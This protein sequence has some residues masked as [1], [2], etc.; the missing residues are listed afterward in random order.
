MKHRTA[1]IVCLLA[2]GAVAA[3]LMAAPDDPT[4]SVRLVNATSVP[5][6]TLRVNRDV[7]YPNLRQ[8]LFTN[9]EATA[10]LSQRYRVTNVETG[11]TVQSPEM[12][13]A[14]KSRQALV[15]MGDFSTTSP[16][17]NLPPPDFQPTPGKTF[18]PNVIFRVYPFEKAEGD[19][20]KVRVINGM[21][22]K[23]LIFRGEKG[24]ELQPGEDMVLGS[25]IP[26]SL[27]QAEVDGRK[28]QVGLTP[29]PNSSGL[30]VFYLKDGGPAFLRIFDSAQ[31]PAAPAE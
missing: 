12:E 18:P 28:L 10:M 23:S 31:L 2:M 4:T 17:G 15:I 29:V 1:M 6:I 16:D 13:F 26:G 14:P 3:P 5:A 27:F 25:Q 22:G 11:V 8:G 7:D 21:P 9:G 20:L 24:G 30:V 19:G